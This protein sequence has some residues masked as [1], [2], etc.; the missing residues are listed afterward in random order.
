[1]EGKFLGWHP[2][3]GHGKIKPDD[4]SNVVMLFANEAPGLENIRVNTLLSFDIVENTDSKRSARNVQVLARTPTGKIG[5]G[6]VK[7]WID[8]GKYGFITPVIGSGDVFVHISQLPDDENGYLSPGLEVEYLETE[9]KNNSVEAH[10]VK[11]LGWSKTNEPLLN[12]ADFGQSGWLESLANL[13]EPETWNFNVSAEE[14]DSLP[15]LRSY[16]FHTFRRLS[17]MAGGI[18]FSKDGK[19]AATNTGLVTPNQEEIYALFHNNDKL[20]R[21][22]WKF[23]G[24]QKASHWDI[25]NHFG[26][27]RPPLADY[28][29]DPSVLLYDRRCNLIINYDHV[30]DHIDRFPKELQGNPYMA[31][32]LLTSAESNTTKRVYRNYKAAIPQFYRDHGGNGS[33]SVQLLLPI[34]LTDPAKADLALVVERSEISETYRSSTIL[35]LEMAY[36]NARLLTR[37][38]N[39]WLQP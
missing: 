29:Q 8:K 23:A 21:Q 34:C 7:T 28:F 5:R 38:D 9:G 19:R 4:D 37:P 18:G 2:S 14:Q 36:K 22:K 33:G 35:T 31:R 26:A 39:E 12:F 32:Q 27:S 25:V 24:F 11:V 20:G 10:T 13:A 3:K 15:I 17:E 1:M 30:M 6:I 16:V